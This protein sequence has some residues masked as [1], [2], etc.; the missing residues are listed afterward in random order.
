MIKTHLKDN[1]LL[2]FLINL[3][4]LLTKIIDKLKLSLKAFS[5]I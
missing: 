4:I 5:Q 3:Y 2:T 1:K